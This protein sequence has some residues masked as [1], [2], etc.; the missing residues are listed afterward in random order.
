MWSS[1]FLASP[2]ISSPPKLS[3]F[4]SSSSSSFSHHKILC[5]TPNPSSTIGI[6]LSKRHLNLS[7]LTLLFNGF[8]LDKAKSTTDLVRFTDSNNGFTLLIP[9][10]YTKVDKAG[11]NALFEEQNNGS[12]NIGVVVSPV[13]IKSL[14]DFGTPQFVADKLINAEKRK[15]STKEAEVVSVGERSGQGQQQV[16]EF[17][18]KIDSTRGGIKRVFSAAFVSSKKLYLLNVVHSDKPENPLDSSTRLLL[19]QVLHS[20]D[21]LPLTM[22]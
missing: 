22:T 17:E 7:V 19:E 11:A 3:L 21:A 2:H 12:N 16:Y 5:F 4:S 1:S 8:L 14:E 13:R 20:F 6:N 18:Y 9:S 15:E 10:S